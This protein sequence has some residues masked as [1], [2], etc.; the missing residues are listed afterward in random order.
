[1][2]FETLYESSKNGELLLM[3]GGMCHFH[4][5]RDGQLTIREIIVT[6]KN[7]GI[8]RKI[9]DY[10]EGLQPDSIFAKC[11]ENLNANKWYAHQG[12]KFEG[13]EITKTGRRLLLWRKTLR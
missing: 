13:E 9:L 10:L 6:H 8:G 11:P 7:Q 4:H 12:F 2:I 3:E 1:M 5:R